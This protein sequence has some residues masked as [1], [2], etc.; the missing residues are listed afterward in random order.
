[1][2]V[3]DV[4]TTTVVTTTAETPLPQAARLLAEHGVS[5]LP[6]LDG[7]GHVIGV[8]SETDILAKER[9]APD[10]EP[11]GIARLLHRTPADDVKHDARIVGE[12][13]SSPVVSTPSFASVATAATRMLEHDVN[14]LPVIDRNELVGIL[15][16]ADLVRAFARTDAEIADDAREQVELQQA[17]AGDANVIDIAVNDGDV[18]LTGAVRR[19]IDANVLPRL[20]RQVPGVVEVRSELS[21]SEPD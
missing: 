17:M 11:H 9:R 1:M 7:E 3:A 12:A 13:M 2:R 4:M 16:R 5:G 18:V 10:D 6:V 15:T 20:V 21:W 19:R 8:L 14:R